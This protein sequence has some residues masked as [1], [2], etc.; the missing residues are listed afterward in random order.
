MREGS[1]VN[2]MVLA[3]YPKKVFG[4]KTSVNGWF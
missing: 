3:S 1:K 2:K 4:V